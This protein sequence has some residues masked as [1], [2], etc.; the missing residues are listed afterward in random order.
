MRIIMSADSITT[1]GYELKTGQ[2]VKSATGTIVEFPG[3]A[4][5]EV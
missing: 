4:N 1:V 3:F 5:I 2:P